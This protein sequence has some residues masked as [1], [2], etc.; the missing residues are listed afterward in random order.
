MIHMIVLVRDQSIK[1]ESFKWINVFA[2]QCMQVRSCRALLF[3]AVLRFFSSDRQDVF[4]H[5]L[6]MP[7]LRLCR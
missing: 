4:F 7:P 6:K 1:V 5:L 3:F 2:F